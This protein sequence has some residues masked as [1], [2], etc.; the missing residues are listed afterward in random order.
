MLP[1]IL[2]VHVPK[3]GGYAL[4]SALSA[5]YGSQNSIR[6]GSPEEYEIFKR[7]TPFEFSRYRL[8]TGHLSLPDF[9]AK[10]I[11]NWTPIAITRDP[12]DRLLSA[13]Y[14]VRGW[15]EHPD[16]DEYMRMS[17]DDYVS[18]CERGSGAPQAWS[19][20]GVETL[21]DALPW[22]ERYK[23]LAPYDKFQEATAAIANLVGSPLHVD[24]VN[25]TT[26]PVTYEFFSPSQSS[27]LRTHLAEDVAL[28]L[29]VQQRWEQRT[30]RTF[31]DR[32]MSPE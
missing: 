3:T 17:L 29:Y 12:L 2:F 21:K 6:F 11:E 18:F 1:R 25:V 5:V 22:L 26:K 31:I 14:Y 13:Y 23:I 10:G 24:R 20:A 27:R 19:L 16:H 30:K 7:M 4:W 28:H 15:D 9:L 8:I 32:K